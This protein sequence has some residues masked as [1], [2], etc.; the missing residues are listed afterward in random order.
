MRD[1]KHTGMGVDE[2]IQREIS[3]TKWTTRCRHGQC[4]EGGTTTG[5]LR[6]RPRGRTGQGQSIRGQVEEDAGAREGGVGMMIGCQG[7]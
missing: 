2:E 7:T 5:K 4:G 6:V 3:R 1:E